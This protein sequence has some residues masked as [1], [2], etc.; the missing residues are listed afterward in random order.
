MNFRNI[1]SALEKK[2]QKI[3]L[4]YIVLNMFN[5]N[6]QQ[7]FV[8]SRS[9]EETP[10]KGVKICSKLTIQ[11]QEQRSNVVLVSLLLTLNMFHTFFLVFLL[12]TL[13]IF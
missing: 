9:T 3:N 2:Q 12:L 7:T 5:V 6:T 4:L 13:N 11:T 1:N 10:E 8:C